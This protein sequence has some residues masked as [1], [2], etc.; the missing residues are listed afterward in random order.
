MRDENRGKDLMDSPAKLLQNS[1]GILEI[2][3]FTDDALV[4]R[5]NGIGGDHHAIGMNTGD[6]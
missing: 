6:V 2:S 1:H 3:R 5:N 4:Q